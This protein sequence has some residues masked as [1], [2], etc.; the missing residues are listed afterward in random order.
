MEYVKLISLRLKEFSKKYKSR[1]E[2]VFFLESDP[3]YAAHYFNSLRG[4]VNVRKRIPNKNILSY[5]KKMF[6]DY[7]YEKIIE[8]SDKNPYTNRTPKEETNDMLSSKESDELRRLKRK[9]NRELIYEKEYELIMKGKINVK[10]KGH[11]LRD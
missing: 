5:F 11:Q 3:D 4:S 6:S 10:K 9:L 8:Q 2:L 1:K 7:E